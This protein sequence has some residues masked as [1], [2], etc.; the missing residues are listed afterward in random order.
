[1]MR[2]SVTVAAAIAAVVIA[3]AGIVRIAGLGDDAREF[4]R[5]TFAGPD[6]SSLQ[7]AAHNE[8]LAAAALL[9][10]AAVPRLG[11]IRVAI[12]G[13]M[14]TVLVINAAPIG[15][16]LSAYGIRAA[17][18]LA[19]HTPLEVAALSLAG[20]ALVTAHRGPLPAVALLGVGVASAALLLIAGVLEA[21]GGLQ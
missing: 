12:D 16:A 11:R 21:I 6:A 15:V 14:T 3:A 18:A 20:G 17:Q 7:L 19:L 9:V 4:L 1:M 8:R 10:A 5:F 2:A 13:V